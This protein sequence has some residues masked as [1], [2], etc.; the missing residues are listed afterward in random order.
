MPGP[1]VE[2]LV[3][4]IEQALPSTGRLEEAVS[5]VRRELETWDA[6]LAKQ[7]EPE[8]IEAT[9]IVAKQFEQIEILHQHSIVKKRP[10]WYFGPKPTDLHWPALKGYLTGTKK[11]HADDVAGID[12]SSN[13]VV[14]LLDNPRD[15]A[16]PQF[17]CRG[18]VVGHVQSGKTANMTAVI[19]KALDAGYDTVIILAGLTNKLRHQTQ[20]RLFTDLV[21][22]NPLN[23][24]VE[25]P[26]FRGGCR[27]KRLNERKSPCLRSPR[28]IAS[29]GSTSSSRRIEGSSRPRSCVGS[30]ESR[31]VGTTSG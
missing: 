28:E 11:W 17:S 24:Q 21:A 29:D 31:P 13:E 9:A 27:V 3:K 19:A 5:A 23:W 18:L 22:R 7:L 12:D 4:R 10:Q 1:Q 14:S 26:D 20:T 30:W 16:R 8:L 15:F 2:A 25:L 6:G